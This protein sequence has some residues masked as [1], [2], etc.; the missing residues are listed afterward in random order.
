MQIFQMKR[1]TTTDIPTSAL[2]GEP[3]LTNVAG[4]MKLWI[5]DKNNGA[6]FEIAGSSY[7]KLMSPAFAGVPTTPYAVVGTNTDQIAS[8]KFVNDSIT[9]G[10]ATLTGVLKFKGT[11][12]GASN[13]LYPVSSVVGDV[14]VIATSGK[15]GGV[16][17]VA[18][19]AGDMVLCIANNG[20]GSQASV[21]ASWRIV[22][23][24]LTGVITYTGTGVAVNEIAMFSNINGSTL[25]GSG[26]S[27]SSATDLG[28]A[29]SADTKLPTQLAVKTYV[30]AAVAA[31][32]SI[33]IDNTSLVLS[34]GIYSVGTIDCGTF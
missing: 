6:A 3:I 12:D 13:P 4:Q 26:V 23:H 29:V 19:D 5:G 25:A 15:I 11:L 14:Y 1:S 7:A 34:G 2:F 8:T 17:G 27:I 9:A 24:N 18:V 22:E 31:G 30:D 28:G 16:D 33:T 10:L 20:G 21:G 32:G